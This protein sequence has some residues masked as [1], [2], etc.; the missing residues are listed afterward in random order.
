MAQATAWQE[1]G[2]G[3]LESLGQS[4]APL[5][6]PLAPPKSQPCPH[7]MQWGAVVGTKQQASLE[8]S[9]TGLTEIL[10]QR[11]LL[12]GAQ[13]RGRRNQECEV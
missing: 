11:G 7:G 3:G 5:T 12:Q 2:G 9:D 8:V 6:A 4:S 1:W 13:P 10:F